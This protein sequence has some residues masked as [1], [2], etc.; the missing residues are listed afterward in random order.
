MAIKNYLSNMHGLLAS[1]SLIGL[2]LGSSPLVYAQDIPTPT[3]PADGGDFNGAPDPTPSP[4]STPEAVPVEGP[5]EENVLETNGSTDTLPAEN[6]LGDSIVP[7]STEPNNSGVLPVG[8]TSEST[9]PV[10][11]APTDSTGESVVNGGS[12]NETRPTSQA[13]NNQAPPN[14]SPRGLW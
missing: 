1:L 12:S 4:E 10:D 9:T 8:D 2:A 13:P 14:N 7:E 3:P 6:T 11:T 5:T